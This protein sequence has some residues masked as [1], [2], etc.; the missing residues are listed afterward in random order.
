MGIMASVLTRVPLKEH[1][2][3][4]LVKYLMISHVSSG[5]DLFHIALFHLGIFSMLDFLL[6]PCLRHYTVIFMAHV[7][8]MKCYRSHQ[9]ACVLL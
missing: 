3:L 2:I 6:Q 5:K 1:A 8:S 4:N 9:A 7:Q